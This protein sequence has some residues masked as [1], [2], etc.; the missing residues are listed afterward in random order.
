MSN[1]DGLSYIINT[2][3]EKVRA[4]YVAHPQ[5]TPAEARSLFKTE[6]FF[7]KILRESGVLA[8]LTKTAHGIIDYE[9]DQAQ[10]EN[11]NTLAD[12]GM[13]ALDATPVRYARSPA[14]LKIDH[15]FYHPQHKLWFGA[16]LEQYAGFGLALARRE[17]EDRGID[18]RVF[19]AWFNTNVFYEFPRGFS[20]GTPEGQD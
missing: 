10:K 15:V 16:T 4:H 17:P 20:P 14:P 5:T 12:I 9:V 11:L 8:D 19:D 13:Q 6:E 1:I 7:L 2:I 18:G 3:R